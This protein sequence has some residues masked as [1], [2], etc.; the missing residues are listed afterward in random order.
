MYERLNILFSQK[1]LYV[2]LKKIEKSEL[3][4]T[5]RLTDSTE[6]DYILATKVLC[7]L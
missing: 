2:F 6:I 1:C 7:T 4:S 3:L 5:K